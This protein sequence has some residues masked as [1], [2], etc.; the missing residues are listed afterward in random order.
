MK[1]IEPRFAG[2]H[3]ITLEDFTKEEIDYM[4]KVS[5]DLKDAFYANED[6][7]EWLKGKTGFLMFF[8]QS[9]RTR[10]SFESGM[11]RLSC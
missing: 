1:K 11:A 5:R 2:R 10:N 8:E 9:T 7:T 6:T 4:L 3:L